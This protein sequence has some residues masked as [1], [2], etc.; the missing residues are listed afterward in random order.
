MQQ[1][2]IAEASRALHRGEISPVDL[3]ETC[4]ERIRR[5]DHQV[6]AWV[7]VDEA[8]ARQT[9]RRAE[10][11]LRQGIDR[12]PLHGIPVGIKDIID[13]AGWPTRAGSPLRAN[14]QAQTDAP[15]VAALRQAGA[16][17]LGKTVT[18]EFACFDPSP[19]RNPWSPTLSHTPGGSSSGSAAAVVM[20]MCLGALGTQTGGSLVRPATYCGIATLKPT[21]GQLPLEGV[22]PVSRHLDHAG[23]MAPCVEDLRLLYQVLRTAPGGPEGEIL[24]PNPDP[25]AAVQPSLLPEEPKPIEPKL[26]P[27][28]K[29]Q[30]PEGQHHLRERSKTNRTV[31]TPRQPPR[32]ARVRGFF[33]EQADQIIQSIFEQTLSRLQAAGAEIGEVH[34]PATFADVLD[35]HT[36]IMAVE[37]A[38]YH[39]PS[40]LQHRSHYG[41]KITELLDQ[42][43]RILAVDY[44]VGLDR[45]RTLRSESPGWLAHWDALIMPATTTTA[46]PTLETTGDKTV[47]AP[48]SCTG[49]PVVAIPCGLAENGLPAGIQLIGR[50]HEEEALLAVA[51]WCQSQIGFCAEVPLLQA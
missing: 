20:G 31:E 17:L 43:L 40:F 8:V 2:T 21:F 12:G 9:A 13:V 49:L 33:A 32:L 37:A 30:F 39:R 10:E 4:L 23:P 29:D 24:L 51:Q 6:R 11:E 45:L 42:G 16:I 7:L 25:P 47:Q 26:F 50:P 34:W 35:L 38:A 44:L 19:T 46:P 48:W 3:V 22:V 18:V 28:E 36:L 27:D 14:H 5:Y 41:P 1:W 15:L